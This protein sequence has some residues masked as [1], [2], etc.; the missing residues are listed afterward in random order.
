MLS[1]EVG[2]ILLD[3]IFSRSIPSPGKFTILIYFTVNKVS[4]CICSIFSLSIY[5]SADGYKAELTSLLF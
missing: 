4:L 3:V 1:S 5:S 2:I